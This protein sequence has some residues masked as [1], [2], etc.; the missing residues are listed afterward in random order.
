MHEWK[1]R[2]DPGY[3]K[4]QVFLRDNGICAICRTDTIPPSVREKIRGR[5]YVPRNQR[6]STWD[7]DHIIPVIKGGGGCGLANYRTLCKPCHKAETKKL[8]G[9]RAA[10]RKAEHG[11]LPQ[12]QS[13]EENGES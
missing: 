13:T 10:A 8:A 6:F 1:I 9:E 4:H 2:T 7:A 5:G 11:R 12:A 3:V